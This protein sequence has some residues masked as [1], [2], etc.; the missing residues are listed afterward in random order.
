MLLN[1]LWDNWKQIHAYDALIR[2]ETL[3]LYEAQRRS[4]YE[5]IRDVCVALREKWLSQ[6]PP[7]LPLLLRY[8]NLKIIYSTRLHDR[9]SYLRL[10]NRKRVYL[11]RHQRLTDE[12]DR[13]RSMKSR[14]RLVVNTTRAC[15]RQ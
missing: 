14:R 1:I 4:C 2:I 11:E 15:L 12:H 8:Q 5:V 3:H 9:Q 7:L 13:R 10:L 6:L